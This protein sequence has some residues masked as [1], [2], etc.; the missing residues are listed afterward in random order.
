VQAGRAGLTHQAWPL[1]GW[2]VIFVWTAG[3][4]ALAVMAYRRDTGKW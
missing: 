2:V 1:E 3:L 4:T